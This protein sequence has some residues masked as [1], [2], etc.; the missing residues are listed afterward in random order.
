MYMDLCATSCKPA[1]RVWGDAR[2]WN[3]LVT[4]RVTLTR[5]VV[6]MS[7]IYLLVESFWRYQVVDLYF[8]HI[9]EFSD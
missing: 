3:N 8:H 9:G 4:S 5:L 6:N 2:W 1:L 7:S